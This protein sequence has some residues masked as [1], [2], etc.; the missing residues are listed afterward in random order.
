MGRK[1]INLFEFNLKKEKANLKESSNLFTI[2][3]NL[4][5]LMDN[6]FKIWG[7]F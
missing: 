7:A 4:G 5:A 3:I 2:Q 6:G 1:V